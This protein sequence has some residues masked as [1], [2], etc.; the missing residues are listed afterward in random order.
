[1]K[2]LKSRRTT[3]QPLADALLLPN[4]ARF[5][6]CALQ[7][8]PFAYLKR[9]AKATPFKS[10]DEYNEAIVVACAEQGIEVRGRGHYREGPN[11]LHRYGAGEKSG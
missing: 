1:M 5:F 9:H 8:N 6:K 3:S 10:E 11:G 7:V 4:G 2:L